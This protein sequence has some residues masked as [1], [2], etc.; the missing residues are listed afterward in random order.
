MSKES[1]DWY[2]GCVAD[3]EWRLNH[4][5]FILNKDGQ[6]E[7]FR[8]NWAQKQIYAKMWHR[9]AILKARQLG[10]ST[11]TS[12]LMLDNA[13]HRRNF[14]AGIIDKG[15]PDGEEKIG[16][17]RFAAQCMLEP[18]DAVQDDFI[19]DEKVREE[20]ALHTQAVIKGVLKKGKVE[21]T[22][23]SQKVELANGSRIVLGTS[24][25]GG[26]LQMLH[27][28]EFGSIAA[29]NPGK[30]LEI[31]SGGVNAV[32]KDGVV[33]IESTHEGGKYGENYR[34]MK[35]AM[36]MRG[37]KL[38][39]LDYKF[40]FFPWYEQA[41]YRLEGG[42]PSEYLSEYFAG[43]EAQGIVLDNA[44]KAW[45]SVQEK[46][47]GYRV[48]TEYPTTPDEAFMQQVHGALYGS[49]ISRLRSQGRMAAEF[50]ADIY[51]P[52]YVSWDIGMTDYTAMWLVQPLAGKFYVIDYYCANDQGTAHY[53]NKVREWEREYNQLITLNILP[54]DAAPPRDWDNPNS[55]YQMKLIKAGFSTVV[56]PKTQDVWRGV[57][58]VKDI[59]PYCVFH[60]RCSE[61]IVVNGI[62]Y[63][64]GVDALENYQSGKTGANG[65]ERT[66][67][68]HD[69]T[70]HGAD[71]F[72]Y[73]AEGF[74]AGYVNKDKPGRYNPDIGEAVEYKPRVC[75]GLPSAWRRSS[76]LGKRQVAN[77]F[78]RQ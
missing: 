61:S 48:K 25:R 59:L 67:P 10:M 32:P 7:R 19:D 62:E 23:M 21:E 12:I 4:M 30:A 52:L 72:R 46:I 31:L 49:I 3:Q 24:L 53:I 65:V 76:L 17:M 47:F 28:S 64:S 74:S 57:Y 50:E 5:Y 38:S 33:I 6:V 36:E 54:H 18:P 16:K 44:Q 73:F 34:I 2:D 75:N 40:F 8:M 13:I 45:Y 71:A 68:L 58:L 69:L 55:S 60:K 22:F 29:N 20:I 27:V 11:F 39:P 63:M 77:H 14:K 15:L 35:Q 70:S 56:L 51:S 66:T 42:E 43:L 1:S 78:V 37:K 41:E 9:N 26:T